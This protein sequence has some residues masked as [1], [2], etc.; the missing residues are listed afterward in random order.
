MTTNIEAN[1][2]LKNVKK[3]F[4]IHVKKTFVFKFMIII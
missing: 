3:P 2:F 4:V 1:I